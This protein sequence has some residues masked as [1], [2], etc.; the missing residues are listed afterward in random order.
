ME[1]YHASVLADFMVWAK[2]NPKLSTKPQTLK[3]F[4]KE[5]NSTTV[6]GILPGDKW[7][8]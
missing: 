4:S 6:L 3:V 2:D 7:S 1:Q 8:Q 5:M